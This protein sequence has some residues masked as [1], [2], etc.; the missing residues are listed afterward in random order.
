MIS[1]IAV[2]DV[3]VLSSEINDEPTD[4]EVPIDFLDDES[5]LVGPKSA[6][7]SSDLEV[8]YAIRTKR[9]AGKAVKINS[10]QLCEDK[11]VLSYLVLP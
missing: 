3:A 1:F 10:L 11:S 2:S 6:D 9:E 4:L 5:F 8:P 7:E